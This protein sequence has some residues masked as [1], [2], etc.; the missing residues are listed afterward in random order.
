MAEIVQTLFGISP[1]SYQQQQS[2]L[3][4]QRALQYAKLDPLQQ[5]NYAIGRGAYGLAGAIGGALGGQDPELQRIT[6]RQQIAGQIDYNDDASMQQAITALSQAGDSQGAMQLQQIRIGQKAKLASI[7]KDEALARQA[8]AAAKREKVAS[9]PTDIQVAQ[10]ISFLQEKISQL[11]NLPASPERDLAL[12]LASGQLS[13]LERLTTKAGEKPLAAN[14]KEVGVAKGTEKAVFLDVNNDQQFTYGV[15]AAGKQVRVPFNG[16]VDRTTSRVSATATG[17][18][19]N[20]FA[21]VLNKKQG[22]AYSNAIDVRNNAITAVK[23]FNT[24]GQLDEQGLISGTFATGR[25]GA[26]NLLTT[27]GLVTP[28]NAATLA[29]SENYQKVAGDA[30]LA[31]L[32]GKLGAQ[33]SDSDRKFIEGLVPQLENSAAARRQLIDFMRNK[34]AELIAASN[35]LIDYAETKKTLS[36][37]KPKIPLPKSSTGTYSDLSDDELDRRIKAAQKKQ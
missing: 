10:E 36:G 26:T 6:M 5:A 29:R 37:Y 31:A 3:A 11:T 32:G 12:R 18:Q 14:I 30:I 22:D 25:V 7:G 34:N 15:D 20:D 27:L 13:Q 21:M 24:L 2:A 19:Q 9:I 1:E 8:E 16:A 4:D 17:A 35:E 28:A 23:T 33:I